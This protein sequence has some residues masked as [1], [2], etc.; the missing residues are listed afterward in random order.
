[1]RFPWIAF[2]LPGIVATAALSVA[3]SS[4]SSTSGGPDG[5]GP[6]DSTVSGDSQQNDVIMGADGGDGSTTDT[7]GGG[8]DGGLV[9]DPG[10][11]NCGPTNCPVPAQLCCF[12][13]GD[14]GTMC[15]NTAGIEPCMIGDPHRCDEAADCPAGSI[16]CGGVKGT[17]IATICVP[18]AGTCPS[19]EAQVCKTNAECTNG[20]SCAAIVCKG[21][22]LGFCGMPSFCP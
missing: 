1:M 10:T 5:G 14:G 8:G 4:S 3:C 19:M 7:G 15:E 17:G 21:E 16:C 13:A 20:M 11:V 12:L 6:M 18:D 9:S 22:T 2:S